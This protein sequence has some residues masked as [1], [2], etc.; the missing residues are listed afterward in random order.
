[1]GNNPLQNDRCDILLLGA[2]DIAHLNAAELIILH[3]ERGKA[4]IL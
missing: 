2:K 1:M 3:Y 4:H